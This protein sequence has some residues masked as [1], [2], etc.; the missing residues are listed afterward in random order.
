[1]F[2]IENANKGSIAGIVIE[3]QKSN[4]SYTNLNDCK[5]SLYRCSSE[6]LVNC[7]LS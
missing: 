1:M 4:F 3:L 2:K 5:A 6:E 7:G